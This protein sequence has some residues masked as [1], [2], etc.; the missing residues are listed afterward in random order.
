[1]SIKLPQ[2]VTL[3]QLE[4]RAMALGVDPVDLLLAKRRELVER[5]TEIKRAKIAPAR[6]L[7]ANLDA[8]R[9]HETGKAIIRMG[10]KIGPATTAKYTAAT[11]PDFKKWV[12][13]VE[14]AEF[15]LTVAY[16]ELALLEDQVQG[17]NDRLLR[18]R[19]L[20]RMHSSEAFLP[21]GS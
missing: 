11:E 5:M 16:A 14:Q 19:D 9:Q 13:A 7:V 4:E 10:E 18:I 12:E 21:A 8:R 1:M 2:T 3:A 6:K 17:I 15:E 20:M